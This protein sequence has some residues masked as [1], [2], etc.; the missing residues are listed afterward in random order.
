MI[1][2]TLMW[3]GRPRNSVMFFFSS[4][5][6]APPRPI[7]MPGFAVKM[8]TVIVCAVRSMSMWLIPVE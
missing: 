6:P 7:I 2:I 4:S 5:M 3:Q 8:F 1:S